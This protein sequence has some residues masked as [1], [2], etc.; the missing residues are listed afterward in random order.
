MKF[1]PLIYLL[2]T[3]IILTNCATRTKPAPVVN[4]THNT[5]KKHKHIQTPKQDDTQVGSMNSPVTNTH[6][7]TKNTNTYH[8][9][10]PIDQSI[11]KTQWMKPIN[12]A[13]IIQPYTVTNK[14]INYT[15][16]IG[17][18]IIAVKDGKVVYSG[19]G[20]KGYGNLIIIKHDNIFISAYA[21]NQQNL[22]HEGEMVK[23]GQKIATMGQDNN[24]KPLLHFEIRQNGK[25]IDPNI[26]IK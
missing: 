18:P 10:P 15:G 4:V 16:A 7:T 21:N 12:N 23:M 20:L 3:A 17:Q 26:I 8:P 2:C 25:P 5:P 11:L 14:G 9:Q 24:K 13:K 1:K 6:Q 22:V 19:N